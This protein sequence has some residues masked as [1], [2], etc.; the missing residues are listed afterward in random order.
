MSHSIT[1]TA[2]CNIRTKEL[3]DDL[4]TGDIAVIKH[5]NIDLIAAE[6][7]CNK[8]I[9]LVINTDKS[10]DYKYPNY[11]TQYIINSNIPLLEIESHFYNDIHN[12]DIIEY[13]YNNNL[14]LCNGNQL[15]YT[16]PLTLQDCNDIYKKSKKKLTENFNNFIKN[17]LTFL[18]EEYPTLLENLSIPNLNI[19]IW[20]KPVLIVIRNTY[21]KQDIK[22]L[23][24]YIKYYNPIIIAVDGA[25]DYLTEQNINYNILVGDMD[26]VSDNCIINT[27]EIIV[28]GYYKEKEKD[29]PGTKRLKKLNINHNVVHFL[30]TSEDLAIMLAYE[31]G[32]SSIATI[33]AHLSWN[34]LLEKGRKGMSSSFLI[35]LKTGH[36]LI[37]IKGLQDLYNTD[38]IWNN[39][40]FKLHIYTLLSI[41]ILS[42]ILIFILLDKLKI[43][44]IIFDTIYNYIYAII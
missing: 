5:R 34:E 19:D 12:N 37:D 14:L 24:S 36:K 29:A 3:I 43:D 2:K 40:N 35:R 4:N 42:I 26:S 1:G 31:L 7:L 17:T 28:H 38:I 27:Q 30:G 6:A 21:T 16:K 18:E 9:I 32:A 23:Q 44:K 22:Y 13:D 25:A 33:G 11:G 15:L 20:N 8:N 10:I 39:N 41:S